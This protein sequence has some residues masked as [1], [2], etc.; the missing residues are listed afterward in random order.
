MKRIHLSSTPVERYAISQGVVWV[1]RE[2]L[3]TPPGMPP[4]SKLRGLCEYLNKRYRQGLRTVGYVETSISMAGW[5]VAAVANQLGMRCVIFDP[6]YKSSDRSDLKVLERHRA[7]WKLAHADIRQIQAGR[8]K[9]NWYQSKTIFENEFPDGELLPLGIPLKETISETAAEWRKTM[10]TFVPACTICCVG[11][12]TIFSGLLQGW[13]DG[14][15]VLIGVMSR[16]GSV[17]IMEEKCRNRS[18]RFGLLSPAS[19]I[20]LMKIID[21]DWE[22]TKPAETSC[23]FPCHPYYDLKAWLWLKQ[24]LGELPK[25]ILFWNIGSLPTAV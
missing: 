13:R 24:N 2:D 12:G 4:F 10:E 17:P 25:P 3:C 18:E 6:Q 8:A 23:P 16:K 14:E 1:K 22:Y 20:P 19:G 11:S 7:E 15:G 21:P 9:V 5:G